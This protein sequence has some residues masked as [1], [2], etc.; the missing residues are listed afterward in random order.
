MRSAFVLSKILIS[1]LINP[2]ALIERLGSYRGILG[3]DLFRVMSEDISVG[4]EL[5]FSLE[6]KSEFYRTHARSLPLKSEVCSS[7]WLVYNRDEVASADPLKMRKRIFIIERGHAAAEDHY[8]WL[9][10]SRQ[11]MKIVF[12]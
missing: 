8:A 1:N 9:L 3:K 4:D 5:S 2:V 12:Y 11:E 7:F 6:S 10:G